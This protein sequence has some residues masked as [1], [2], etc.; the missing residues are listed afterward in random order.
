MKVISKEQIKALMEANGWSIERAEGY[1]DGETY[2][3]RDEKPSAYAQIGIDEYSQG[4]RAGFYERPNY[5]SPANFT[6]FSI[7]RMTLRKP[8]EV[9]ESVDARTVAAHGG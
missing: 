4:F 1:A 6:D 9:V 7:A 3:R 2:R 5:P 8:A